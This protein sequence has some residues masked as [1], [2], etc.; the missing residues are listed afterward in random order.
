MLQF[1][2]SKILLLAAILQS[3]TFICSYAFAA[4]DTSANETSANTQKEQTSDVS[5][6]PTTV[7]YEVLAEIEQQTHSISTLQL[8]RASLIMA[9]ALHQWNPDFSK[10]AI[11]ASLLERSSQQGIEA[12]LIKPALVFLDMTYFHDQPELAQV[13]LRSLSELN[14]K[15]AGILQLRLGLQANE[16]E[17][18]DSLPG[19]SRPHS[20][21]GSSQ[22]PSLDQILLGSGSLDAKRAKVKHGPEGDPRRDERTP[23][24]GRSTEAKNGSSLV[25]KT[26]C[27][28]SCVPQAS[29]EA[30]G[31]ASSVG[32]VWGK[33]ILGTIAGGTSFNSCRKANC[34]DAAP[35]T[36]PKT[37]S[38]NG[39]SGGSSDNGGTDGDADDDSSDGGDKCGKSSTCQDE[40]SRPANDEDGN[41]DDSGPKKPGKRRPR[42]PEA[43]IGRI[44]FLPPIQTVI[45]PVR[46]FARSK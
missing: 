11:T 43:N 42:L 46:P 32:N 44:G 19:L 37:D 38:D 21:M 4:N 33:A 9:R 29:V 15:A 7:Y 39:T 35:G 14:P 20:L 8:E 26:I 41:V 18:D 1:Q 36:E 2:V 24:M 34:D 5:F 17:G 31:A 22:R 10:E 12:G 28:A 40:S 45:N 23:I 16:D 3:S 13:A 27:Y 30:I 25:D 6:E